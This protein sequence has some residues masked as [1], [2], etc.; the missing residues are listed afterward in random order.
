RAR[1]PHPRRLAVAP[2]RPGADPGRHAEHRGRDSHEHRLRLACA[3]RRRDD[4]DQHRPRLPDL[5]RAELPPDRH[6]PARDHPDRPA[7]AAARS[8]APAAARALDGGA[9][10]AGVLVSGLRH[11]T[12]WFLVVVALLWAGWESYLTLSAAHRL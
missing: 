7:V 3:H 2:D 1:G 11:R 4:R 8:P 9:L 12:A 6:H 10:G 5:Q